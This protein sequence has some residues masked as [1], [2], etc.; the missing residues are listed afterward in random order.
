M[1]VVCI[2]GLWL[3]RVGYKDQEALVRL[4]VECEES[5]LPG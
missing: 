5:T 1:C 2:L 4:L 3:G